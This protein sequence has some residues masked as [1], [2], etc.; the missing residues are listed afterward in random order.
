MLCIQNHNQAITGVRDLGMAA[1]G[2]RVF[3]L[4]SERIVRYP[5][6]SNGFDQYVN[7]RSRRDREG[8]RSCGQPVVATGLMLGLFRWQNLLSI[9]D[10]AYGGSMGLGVKGL[11][12]WSNSHMDLSLGAS[13]HQVVMSWNTFD[14]QRYQPGLLVGF[15]LGV[16]STRHTLAAPAVRGTRHIGAY[17]L[18]SAAPMVPNLRGCLIAGG[19]VLLSSL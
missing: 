18:D 17:N 1:P 12:A 11:T 14:G 19:L 2:S 15:A 8:S 3:G 6:R 4:I 13:K 7:G 5:Q 16:S 10:T 9:I